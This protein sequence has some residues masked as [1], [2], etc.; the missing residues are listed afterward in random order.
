MPLRR[1]RLQ[2]SDARRQ[3]ATDCWAHR[4]TFRR[5]ADGSALGGSKSSVA[6]LFAVHNASVSDAGLNVARRLSMTGS[7]SSPVGSRSGS[8][9]GGEAGRFVPSQVPDVAAINSPFRWPDG[10]R[11][12]FDRQMEPFDWPSLSDM[13]A[14]QLALAAHVGA[15]KDMATHT[16]DLKADFVNGARANMLIGV[17]IT[18]GVVTPARFPE[19]L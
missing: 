9:A 7:A 14:E 17:M 10:A 15:F 2:H 13:D 5:R 16:P 6:K 4:E 8:A 1:R 18:C 19:Q 3:Q 11:E 12:T